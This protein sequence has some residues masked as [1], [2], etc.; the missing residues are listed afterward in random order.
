MKETQ[1]IKFTDS[2]MKQINDFKTKFS[3]ITAKLGEVEVETI[4][5]E[6]QMESLKKYKDGLKTDYIKLR[7]SEVK[8]ANE[9]KK[10]YGEGELD[11]NTGI[12]KSSN[13]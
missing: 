9:L 13:S 1:V 8:L 11:I 5:V 2:E 7:E 12:F 6:K 4:L 10:K 3:E